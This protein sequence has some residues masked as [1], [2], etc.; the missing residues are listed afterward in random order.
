[1]PKID[2]DASAAAALDAFTPG[3]AVVIEDGAEVLGVV[4]ARSLLA[5]LQRQKELE[6]A[7]GAAR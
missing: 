4:T 7:L 1:M 5:Q 2:A 6:A 3:G